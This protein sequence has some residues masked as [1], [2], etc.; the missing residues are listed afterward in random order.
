MAT[1]FIRIGGPIESAPLNTNFRKL[2]NDITMSNVNLKFSDSD[3]IKNNI[4][5]ML[6]IKKPENGQTCYVI[7]N[8]SLYRYFSGDSQWHQIADFGQTYRQGFLNSG[9][10]VMT[11]VINLK[12]DTM[13]VLSIPQMLVYYKTLEGDSTYLRG[14]YKVESQE[15]DLNSKLTS[16]STYTIALDE[17]RKA[18][19]IDGMI[20]TDNPNMIVLGVI[21]TDNDG[22]VIEDLICTVPNIPYTA[23]RGAFLTRGGEN[24]GLD[25]NG[26]GNK[27]VSRRE[28]IYYLE[29]INVTIGE[30]DNYSLDKNNGVNSNI[31]TFAAKNND[32]FVYAY[33]HRTLNNPFSQ[34]TSD[35][36]INKYYNTETGLLEELDKSQYTIQT[37]LILPN[38]KNIILYGDFAYSSY[39]D[40]EAH[41]NDERSYDFVFPYIEATRMVVGYV[42]NFTTSNNT[43]FKT[44][45]LTRLAQAGTVD[46]QFADDE[47]LIYSGQDGIITPASVR[48]NL[49]NLTNFHDTYNIYFKPYQEK[50]YLF[51]LDE[52]YTQNSNSKARD[53]YSKNDYENILENGKKGYIIPT[54]H[55]I[56]VIHSRLD[57]IETELWKIEQKEGESVLPIYNQGVR[58]RLEKGEKGLEDI[59]LRINNFFSQI[60]ELRKTKVHKNTT[61]NNHK[62]GK[63]INDP[64]EVNTITLVTGDIEEGTSNPSQTLN[65]W[66]TVKKVLDIPEIGSTI[67]HSTTEGNPHKTTTDQLIQGN[68]KLVSSV[69]KGKIAN[70]PN[71]TVAELSKKVEG[72]SLKTI[73]G[74]SEQAQAGAILDWGMIKSLRLYNDGIKLQVDAATQTA[75]LECVGQADP[76]DFLKRTQ[77]APTSMSDSNYHGYVDKAI[78]AQNIESLK[79]LAGQQTKYYG[80][81]DDGIIGTY[82]LPVTTGDV[83]GAINVED[84]V[85][86]PYKHSITLKHLADATV[87]Y[88]N[89]NEEST[90]N[91]NVYDL[92]KHH[93]HK[94]YN[95]GVQEEYDSSGKIIIHDPYYN[96]IAPFGGLSERAYYFTHANVCYTFTPKAFI[97]AN[98]E[99]R[100][101]PQ[102]TYLVYVNG[103][104]ET[105]IQCELING[106]LVETDYLLH[107]VSSTDWN[108]INE[109]NFGDNLTVSVVNGR[110]T[111][112][113]KDVSAGG[114][115][116][117]FANLADVNV[118]Y[119]DLNLG[120]LLMLAK[121]AD[122]N[123]MIKLQ[124]VP[125]QEYM[126]LEDY[127]DNYVYDGVN[128]VVNKSNIA[129]TAL[130]A[131]KLQGVYTVN[132]EK[133]DNVSLWTSSQ[134]RAWTQSKIDNIP[135]THYGYN[136]PNS[137]LGHDGDIYILLED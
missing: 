39:D 10:V 50:D 51:A 124:E 115:T 17:N 68:L 113:A 16:G 82:D 9:V 6:E 20:K 76:S 86:E 99:L 88:T 44:Y 96:Y 21:A 5:E 57:E 97:P 71:D 4:K 46:P 64:S 91:T 54:Q 103:E 1:D 2:R 87:V 29:G 100:F 30:I 12:K 73:G 3:G 85:F 93:Y 67:R 18:T 47:F 127:I 63:D 72:L 137:S 109:W 24:T 135:T 59:N 52:Q 112:N 15:L 117:S 92:V 27:K 136:T 79:N 78:T 110:A 105:E 77:Y 126:R 119:N 89:N 41:L 65:Q 80:T 28:G 98:T 55:N 120:K 32:E 129:N 33:P 26:N 49:D 134:I 58:Y 102:T 69:E 22:N 108:C 84:V 31:R 19:C 130:D 61:I 23:D 118:D 132:N 111:I 13:N 107:F 11:N 34:L 36:I 128:H 53:K 62:L 122:S 131:N 106:D 123:Y 101:Y 38:G 60:E 66:F 104:I 45:T 75:T 8:G 70:L 90:L 48:F 121:D 83:K 7:S 56:D 37:H 125:L 95:S 43:H 116:N 133:I 114:F 40:A 74:N 42:D 81:N 14:M 94:V 35:L 25:L